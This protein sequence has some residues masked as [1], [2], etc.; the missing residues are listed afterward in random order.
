MILF[1]E[2][3]L[4]SPMFGQITN[5]PTESHIDS[6]PQSIQSKNLCC[7]HPA[8]TTM[9]W[10]SGL[11]SLVKSVVF[12]SFPSF[13]CS[14]SM[15]SIWNYFEYIYISARICLSRTRSDLRTVLT[16]W[17]WTWSSSVD[18][19]STAVTLQLFSSV[20]FIKQNTVN[21]VVLSP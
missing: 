21:T 13:C 6:N 19:L 2:D 9:K 12:I 5:K 8:A 7:S 16:P 15:L 10:S 1:G 14:N 18:I 20:S 3:Q 4:W 11:Q 17:G